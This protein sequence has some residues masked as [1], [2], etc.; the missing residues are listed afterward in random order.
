M[1]FTNQ[2]KIREWLKSQNITNILDNI[3]INRKKKSD[4]ENYIVLNFETLQF[5]QI[6][7]TDL[8]IVQIYMQDIWW[9]WSAEKVADDII[10]IFPWENKRFDD[11]EVYQVLPTNRSPEFTLKGQ[12]K[13]SLFFQIRYLI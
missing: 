12:Y 5:N 2:Q 11:F 6:E 8:C 9:V 4:W 3:S 10:D 7:N 1:K 13:V